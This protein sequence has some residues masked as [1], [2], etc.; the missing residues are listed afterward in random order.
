MWPILTDQVAWSVGLSVK[1]V[2]P[3]KTAA[4]IELQF[5]LRTWVDQGNH[6]LDGVQIPP[7][8][9]ANFWGRMGVPL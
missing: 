1:L 2:S 7:W 5:G 6:V 3:A 9:G 8:E 4:P